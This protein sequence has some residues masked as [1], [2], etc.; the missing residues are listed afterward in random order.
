MAMHPERDRDHVVIFARAPRLG[1]VKTRLAATLGHPE[2]LRVYRWLAERTLGTVRSG[3]QWTW[4]VRFTPHD[5]GAEIEQWLG[6]VPAHPQAEG[7]LGERMESAIGEALA[8]GATSVVVIGTDCPGLDD[9]LLRAAFHAL[10]E[11]DVV[12]GPASDG[13]Y[14]LVG[15]RDAHR[16]L[17]RGIPWSCAETLACTVAAARLAG[18][19]VTLLE[20]RH[21]IDTEPDWRSWCADAGCPVEA[22]GEA[23]RRGAAE[24]R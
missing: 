5:A 1:T 22:P 14:Y 19:R 12:L 11:T 23:E 6:P 17:F 9:T 24:S 7:D 20:E 4:E 10:R 13:G 15:M 8:A 21:D 3:E 18:L 16:A 2:A